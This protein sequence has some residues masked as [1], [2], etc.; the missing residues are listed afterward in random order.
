MPR[1]KE[2][3]NCKKNINNLLFKFFRYATLANYTERDDTYLMD[4]EDIFDFFFMLFVVS[5]I[6]TWTFT[7]NFKFY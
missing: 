7:C 5:C 4:K 6:W 2:Y 1:N 3:L